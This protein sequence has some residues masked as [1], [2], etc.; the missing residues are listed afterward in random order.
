MKTTEELRDIAKNTTMDTR[1]NGIFF[2]S[3]VELTQKEAMKVQ[4]MKGKNPLGYSFM[5]YKVENGTTTWS[6]WRSC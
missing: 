6:C 3:K 5:D 2:E 1:W 4:T